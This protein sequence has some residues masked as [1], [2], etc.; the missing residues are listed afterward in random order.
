MDAGSDWF[1]R[2]AGED[3]MPAITCFELERATHYQGDRGFPDIVLAHTRRGA[4]FAELKTVKGR[5]TGPQAGWLLTLELA[6]LE[7]CV[8]TPDDWD[9]IVRRLS[10][11]TQIRGI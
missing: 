3:S 9:S 6:G 5:V 10:T 2:I 1:R 8:W 11:D 4:I 7:S